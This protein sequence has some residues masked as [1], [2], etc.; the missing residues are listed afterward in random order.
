[1]TTGH[2]VLRPAF[3]ALLFASVPLVC[4]AQPIAPRPHVLTVSGQGEVRAVP[5]EAQLSAGVTTQAKTAAEALAANS[6]AMTEVFKALRK[7]DIPEKSISTSNFSITPQHPAYR[8]DMPDQDRQKIIGYQVS[9]QVTVVLDDTSKVGATLDALVAS[10]ANQASG[11]SFNIRDPKPLMA[12]ARQEA[13]KDAMAKAQT[14]AKAAGVSLGPI[15]SIGEGGGMGPQPMY[16]RALK[17]SAMAAAPPT[18]MAAGEQ[19]VT[20]NVSITWEI[21]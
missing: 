3:G 21:Q 20:A 19:T 18:P 7:R 15:L 9:T 14:L 16:E 11:V 1:M 5:D 12:Q 6:T 4:A 13:V 2:T 8:Q 17:V 10:G